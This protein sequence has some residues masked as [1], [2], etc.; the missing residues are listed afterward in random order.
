MLHSFNINDNY[1]DDTVYAVLFLYV[2]VNEIL[3]RVVKSCT[4]VYEFLWIQLH[5]NSAPLNS[6]LNCNSA[7][8]FHLQ[9]K[10]NSNSLTELKFKGHLQLNSKW[11]TTLVCI[12]G[13]WGQSICVC[14]SE[15]GMLTRLRS[16]LS[17]S[18]LRIHTRQRRVRDGDPGMGVP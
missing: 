10:I 5:F 17:H 8:C 13:R 9:L 1:N 14:E 15:M 3:R 18:H 12:R 16:V 2:N 11:Q 6:I 7:S 4:Y